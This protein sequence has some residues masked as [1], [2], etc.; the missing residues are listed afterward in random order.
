MAISE[1]PMT[2]RYDKLAPALKRLLPEP[3]LGRLGRVVGFIR[4]LRTIQTSLFVFSVVMSR[5]GHGRPGFESARQWYERLG[6][7]SLG[8]RPIQLRFKSR[9]AVRLMEE[10]F[11]MAV[12]HPHAIPESLAPHKR[13]KEY[14]MHFALAVRSYRSALSSS[15]KERSRA[16]GISTSSSA[17]A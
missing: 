1:A 2:S 10:V 9:S 17:S 15:V 13:R 8:R 3:A 14:A 6:G 5:F 7:P 16:G 12:A 4:R 11:E